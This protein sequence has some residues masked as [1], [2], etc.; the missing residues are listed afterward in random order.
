VLAA[1]R[2]G[3]ELPLL[4]DS[5]LPKEEQQLEAMGIPDMSN[6]E[7]TI[8]DYQTTGLSTGLHPMTYYRRWVEEHG[9]H[10]CANLR[11]ETNGEELTV[12]GGVICRQRPETAKGFVFLTLEDETGMANIIVNPKVF[13]QYRTVLLNNDFLAI[14]GK[15]QLEEGVCNVIANHVE[16]LP[17]ISSDLH[18]CS[19]DF[20]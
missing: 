2:A 5:Q 18:L 4:A 10:S 9:I 1:A 12:A 11:R 8:A 3:K 20:H 15:L 7:L 13:D 6:L 14:T 19:R 16:P 17:S